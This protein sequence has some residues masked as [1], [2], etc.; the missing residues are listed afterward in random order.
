MS[1]R[2]FALPHFSFL[3]CGRLVF[4]RT[5]QSHKERAGTLDPALAEQLRCYTR[6]K[7]A[8]MPIPPPMQSV[9][10]PYWPPVRARW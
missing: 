3:H 1:V 8:A 7:I 2:R 4:A 6:S 5:A 10:R 9:T